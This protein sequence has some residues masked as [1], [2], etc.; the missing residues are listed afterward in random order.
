MLVRVSLCNSASPLKNW[1]TLL[2]QFA[3]NHGI[4]QQISQMFVINC[5]SLVHL[6]LVTWVRSANTSARY[7]VNS[8]GCGRVPERI[9]CRLCV[10]ARGVGS[11]LKLDEEKGGGSGAEAPW[12]WLHFNTGAHRNAQKMCAPGQSCS[13][14]LC[15]Q[16]AHELETAGF[17]VSE[18]ATHYESDTVPRSTIGRL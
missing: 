18:R 7:S 4:F 14:Q 5:V 15:W 8:T 6:C 9:R 10:L 3:I 1:R 17:V 11:S 12:S 2:K 13:N 16:P